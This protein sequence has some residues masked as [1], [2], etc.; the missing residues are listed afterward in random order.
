MYNHRVSYCK[1]KIYHHY[2]QTHSTFSTEANWSS[3]SLT[4]QSNIV[5]NASICFFPS[6]CL[7]LSVVK[8]SEGT[9][10]LAFFVQ[11]ISCRR[12]CL[13]PWLDIGERDI[14]SLWL[15]R[16]KWI[17]ERQYP[18]TMN[19]SLWS[20]D[21]MFSPVEV[22]N[23]TQIE[24]QSKVLDMNQLRLII[25]TYNGHYLTKHI[26]H[27]RPADQETQR[28]LRYPVSMHRRYWTG[29]CRPEIDTHM[30]WR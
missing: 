9:L 28:C 11:V 20:N 30:I 6:K 15:H 22:N 5:H 19:Y 24:L 10:I 27:I 8:C 16:M 7:G 26:E 18:L 25:K 4:E 23:I 14:G 21:A 3:T 13:G 12:L 1:N 2:F 17:F 29:I